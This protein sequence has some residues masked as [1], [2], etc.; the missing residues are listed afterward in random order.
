MHNVS[1]MKKILFLL[2]VISIT[3]ACGNYKTVYVEPKDFLENKNVKHSFNRYSIVVHDKKGDSYQ[4]ENPSISGDSILGKLVPIQIDTTLKEVEIDNKEV[5][6]FLKEDIEKI[7]DTVNNVH[8]TKQNLS[9]VQTSAKDEASLFSKIGFIV[10]GVIGGLLLLYA[11]L[12]LI[13]YASGKAAESSSEGSNSNSNSDSGSQDSADGSNASS[14]GSN[15]SSDGSDS[16]SDGSNSGCFIATM[17]YG[18][19]SAPEVITFRAFRDQ[20][21]V[22]YKIGRK[23][24]HWYYS[25]SPQFVAKYGNKKWAHFLV[26]ASLTPLLCILNQ[27]YKG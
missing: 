11:T 10:L 15:A 4:L 20:V 5:H 22:N 2:I 8:I 27:K 16:S 23:F 24:I 26:K 17:A 13:I 25:Y 14:D 1:I 19:Y 6:L 18:S 9:T 7:S 21:L 12:A 3:T